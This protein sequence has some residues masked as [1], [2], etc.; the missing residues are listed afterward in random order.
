M[1]R[2]EPEYHQRLED[3]HAGGVADISPECLKV[4]EQGCTLGI[5]LARKKLS[6]GITLEEVRAITLPTPELPARLAE[7]ALPSEQVE[8]HPLTAREAEQA[9]PREQRERQP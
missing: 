2:Q 9:L 7:Q 3:V 4:S 5:I 6:L 1:E 8:R